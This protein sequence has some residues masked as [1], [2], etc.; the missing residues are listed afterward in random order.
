MFVCV[1]VCVCFYVPRTRIS[2]SSR[3]LDSD[4]KGIT[5][6]RKFYKY[7]PNVMASYFGKLASLRGITLRQISKYMTAENIN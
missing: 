6:L 7:L 2:V 5:I 3:R 1:C 4:D